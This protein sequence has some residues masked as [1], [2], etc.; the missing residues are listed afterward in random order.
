MSSDV[1]TFQTYFANIFSKLRSGTLFKQAEGTQPTSVLN[2]VRNM[3]TAQW[4]TVG[5]V[6]AEVIGFFSVGEMIGR[7][8][9]VGYR[10]SA[11]AH[12]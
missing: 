2:R 4:A 7:M 12:H 10:S 9:I 3:P 8:K 5:I 6:A 11:P 1:A